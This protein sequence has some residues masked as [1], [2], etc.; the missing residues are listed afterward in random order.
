MA[1]KVFGL[2]LIFTNLSCSSG[3]SVAG[4]DISP[5]DTTNTVFTEILSQPDSVKHWYQPKVY[6]GS[7]WCFRHNQWEDVRIISTKHE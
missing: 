3:W 7:N 2:V 1:T 6:S 4:Y 5:S